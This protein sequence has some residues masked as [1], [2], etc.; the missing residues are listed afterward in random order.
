MPGPAS[1]MFVADRVSELFSIFSDAEV[2]NLTSGANKKYYKMGSSGPDLFFFAPDYDVIL[3]PS[4]VL[5]YVRDVVQPIRNIYKEVIE[6]VLDVIND[7]EESA[8]AVLD[9]VT[10]N[11]VSTVTERVDAINESLAGIRDSLIAHIFSESFNMFDMMRPPHQKD[12]EDIDTGYWFDILHSRRTGKFLQKMWDNANTDEQKAYVLGYATHVAADV[13][14]HPYINQAVGG[15]ARG[16]NARHHFVEN[17]IDVWFYDQAITPSINITSAR[18]HR[19]LPYGE[20]LDDEGV[21][22][23]VLEGATEMKD[24]LK[25]IFTMVS[26]SMDDT[27]PPDQRPSRLPNG[28]TSAKDINLAYWLLLASYK[29]STDSFIPRPEEPLESTLDDIVE[30]VQEF[31]DNVTNPPKR[32]S[33]SPSF[34]LS[35]WSSDCDFSLDALTEWVEYLWDNVVYLGELIGWAATVLK[36]LFDVLACTITA[37]V[38]GIVSSLLWLIQSSLYGILEEIRDALV[39]GAIVHPQPEWVRTNPIALEIVELSNRS[40]VDVRTRSYPHRAQPSNEPFLSYPTTPVEGEPTVPGPY[41]V[42][43]TPAAF[44]T[45]IGGSGNIDLLNEYAVSESPEDTRRLEFATLREETLP[46]VPLAMRL[47]D[48]LRNPEEAIPDWNLDADRGYKYKNWN[49]DWDRLAFDSELPIEEKWHETD[50]ID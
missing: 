1:H 44:L 35:F 43:S 17:I 40:W 6:P 12:G 5:P 18:L 23:A 13:S 7:F 2:Y 29:V 20:E 3:Y 33:S 50:D 26:Q 19:E 25:S 16:Y 41:P 47:F 34:C 28:V 32:P 30:A 4:I 42:G 37:P 38:K 24:D 10:C 49:A 45:G 14:G 36:D 21:F 8:E 27:F 15:A 11:S 39:L 46:A 9:E 31:L 48:T 22:F